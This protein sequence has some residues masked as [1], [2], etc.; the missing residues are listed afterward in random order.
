MVSHRE[1]AARWTT[2]A[3]RRRASR[4]PHPIEDFL[5]TYYPFSFGKLEIWHPA[6]GTAL[7][8]SDEIDTAFQRSPYRRVS[9]TVFSDPAGLSAKERARLFWI[10]DLLTQTQNRAPVFSCHGLHEWAM[11]Y[12]GKDI[13]HETSTPL[14]LSQIEIDSVVES[15]PM[16]C[17]HFDAFR[18]FHPEAQKLNRVQPSLNARPD[19]EQPGCVHANMDLYKWASKAMPWVGSE[20]LIECFE[21]AL[22]LRELDMR[23]SPYDLSDYGLAAI[24]IETPR[25]RREYEEIQRELSS[26][27]RG[28]REGLIGCLDEVLSDTVPAPGSC[29]GAVGGLRPAS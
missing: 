14:R 3:K 6:F 19:F 8:V 4:I 29:H 13:R 25:G 17:T 20:T 7:E 18:F 12:R 21:L 27:A 1:R 2:P 9:N 11:V 15:R 16:A 24:T 10:Q 5:F 23:A 22:R 28:L 26:E